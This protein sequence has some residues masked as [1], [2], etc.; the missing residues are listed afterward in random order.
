MS[1]RPHTIHKIDK[2]VEQKILQIRKQLRYNSAN[3]KEILQSQYN[4][5]G[6]RDS[7]SNFMQK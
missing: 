2:K 6:S 7:L 5:N 1:R 4:I 3:I